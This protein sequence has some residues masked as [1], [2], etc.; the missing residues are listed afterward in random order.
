MNR[1]TKLRIA[2]ELFYHTKMTKEQYETFKAL[3][4][5]LDLTV[6]DADL[7]TDSEMEQFI[8]QYINK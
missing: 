2:K 1:E 5:E 4:E 8:P 3:A 7:L 6:G